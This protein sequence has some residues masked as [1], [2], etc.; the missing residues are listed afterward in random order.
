M[1]QIELNRCRSGA[2]AANFSARGRAS[3]RYVFKLNHYPV[4]ALIDLNPDKRET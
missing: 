1:V 3:Y 2:L 4:L